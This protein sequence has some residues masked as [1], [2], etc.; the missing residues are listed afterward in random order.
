[1]FEYSELLDAAA[2]AKSQEKQISLVAA[3]TKLGS[4]DTFLPFYCSDGAG[5]LVGLLFPPVLC[6]ESK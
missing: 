4:R 5:L 6:F 2:L 3:D 1:M